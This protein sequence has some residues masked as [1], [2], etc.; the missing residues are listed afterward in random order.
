ML[1]PSLD[2]RKFVSSLLAGGVAPLCGAAADGRSLQI[3]GVDVIVTNPPQSSSQNFVLVKVATNEPELCGWGDATCT[4]SE[5]AVAK[6]LEEHLAPAMIGRDPTR[7]ENI[8]QTLYHLPYYRGGSVHLS[9]IS[10]IDMAL[11][12]ILGKLA[13]LPV[14]QLLGGRTRDR[15][16]TY[17][18]TGGRSFKEV[19]DGVRR[20]A[21]QG[22]RV[23]KV[24][25]ADPQ[26]KSGYAV[27]STEEQ[28]RDDQDAF[29]QGRPPRQVWEPDSYVR[30]LPR[31]LGHLRAEFG[32]SLHFLHDVH[33]RITP[34]QALQ[35]ARDVEP[36]KLFYFEDPLRPEH[37]DTFRMMRRQTSTPIAMGEVFTGL[38]EGR[39]LIRE[40]LIDY[41][42]HDL[43]HVGG[44]TAGKKIATM[45][46]PYGILTAWHGP[47]NIS[48]ITHM[49]NCHVSLNV[50]NF[51]IQEFAHGWGQPI[52][53]VFT[54][55]PTYAD[56]HVTIDNKPGLG[57]DVNEEAAKKYPYKRFLR[58]TIRRGDDTPWAY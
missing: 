11:W 39:E 15:L 25:I 57:I 35:L 9:A 13:G 56:G 55:M 42:R 33:E 24:Q 27:P 37:L 38:W 51:G 34:S 4:G 17:R 16:L 36:Y 18:S 31:L 41:V 10:G 58:P 19:E 48:P 3:R 49:A 1:T 54:S 12:D 53:E 50:T 20:L 44:V 52:R 46:E 32:D 7:V 40:H 8:F 6:M 14:Y 30:L 29:R 43:A 26:L 5:L 21:E 28:R 22:Y 47:G 2:R 45:C 23:I